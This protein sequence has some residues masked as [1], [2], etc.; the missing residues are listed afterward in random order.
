MNLIINSSPKEHPKSVGGAL[1]E[2]LALRLG[3][4]TQTIRIYDSDQTYFNYAFRDDWIDMLISAECLIIPVAMWNFTIP[5]ALKDFIDK[6]GKP[7]KL[8]EIKDGKFRGLL[9][10]RPVYII[11]TSGWYYPPDSAHDFVI[12]YLKTVLSSFG[13]HDIRVFRVGGVEGSEELGKD[14]V[15]LD[16]KSG[17]ML[18]AF[19]IS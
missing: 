16:A 9:S 14:E 6:T 3:G 18:K 12:P 13:I 1:A 8:W 4:S 17:E 2:R 10:D 19:G 7:G 11:M 5:A 15:F